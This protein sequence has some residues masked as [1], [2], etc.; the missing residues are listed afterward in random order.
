MYSENFKNNEIK[1]G[2]I[3]SIKGDILSKLIYLVYLLDYSTIY[4]AVLNKIDPTPV[5]S[6][7][8]IK[9]QLK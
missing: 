6:I 2:E 8:Y 7:D 9:S 5:K 1:Y 3:S 4:K